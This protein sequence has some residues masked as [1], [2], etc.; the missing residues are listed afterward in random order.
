MHA[1]SRQIKT[2]ICFSLEQQIPYIPFQSPFLIVDILSIFKL[3]LFHVT[4]P[5]NLPF[6]KVPFF[7]WWSLAFEF[8]EGFCNIQQLSSL[9]I[10]SIIDLPALSVG[11]KKKFF[12]QYIT[13][14]H[15]CCN[16]SVYSFPSTFSYLMIAVL[17]I[18][19]LGPSDSSSN[20]FG[21]S[22]WGGRGV[23]DVELNFFLS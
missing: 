12:F 6:A 13:F 10:S 8:F 15:S 9:T 1:F 21:W 22:A 4:V 7:F 5:L 18:R 23:F 14:L 20:K 17:Y 2:I 11:N 3:S 16:F 19:S